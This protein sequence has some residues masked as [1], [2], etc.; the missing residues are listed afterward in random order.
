MNFILLR[1]GADGGTA[2]TNHIINHCSIL[3]DKLL[4]LPITIT[5]MPLKPV[6]NYNVQ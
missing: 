5:V 1:H 6:W 2:E 3:T 4:P